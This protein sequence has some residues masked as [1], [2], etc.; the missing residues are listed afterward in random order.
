LHCRSFL[1]FNE[2]IVDGRMQEI[3]KYRTL[4]YEAPFP[5]GTLQF[6]PQRGASG[7]PLRFPFIT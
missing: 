3:Y 2:F 1:K 7:A 4:I 6:M 5:S